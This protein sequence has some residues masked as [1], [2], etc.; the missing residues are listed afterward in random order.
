MH[1][2]IDKVSFLTLI[3]VQILHMKYA[4]RLLIKS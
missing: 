4:E 2:I 3:V 1:K